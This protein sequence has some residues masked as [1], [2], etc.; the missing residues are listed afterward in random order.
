MPYCQS[1]Q[2]YLRVSFYGESLQRKLDSRKVPTSALQFFYSKPRPSKPGWSFTNPS[3]YL[4]LFSWV[5]VPRA[6]LRLHVPLEAAFRM[7]GN[8]WR[9]SKRVVLP[10][11]ALTRSSLDYGDFWI[12]KF[13]ARAPRGVTS[14][15]NVRDLRMV[16]PD[17]RDWARTN[18]GSGQFLRRRSAG[19]AFEATRRVSR[20]ELQLAA[21]AFVAFG[22]G[23][24]TRR[25]CL[26]AGSENG[27]ERIFHPAVR[28]FNGT[29]RSDCQTGDRVHGWPID[30]FF[31]RLS[32]RRLQVSASCRTTF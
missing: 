1:C 18:A 29:G 21:V 31:H 19:K 13:K 8:L 20:G 23:L 15:S 25:R 3:A 32:A 10:C 17:G 6:L 27:T 4:G 22:R 24:G 30:C 26:G 14:S 16:Y 2:N 28:S 9:I 7:P 11:D 12:F 5:V